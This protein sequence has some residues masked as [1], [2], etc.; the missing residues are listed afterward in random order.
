MAAGF[1]TC[2][3]CAVVAVHRMEHVIHAGQSYRA[4]QCH[5]CGYTWRVLET[6]EH[7]PTAGD[8][9]QQIDRSRTS[10]LPDKRRPVA[11]GRTRL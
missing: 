7:V 2:P 5:P 8:D 4:F 10:Q 9:A 1:T 3:K 11:N 6:G